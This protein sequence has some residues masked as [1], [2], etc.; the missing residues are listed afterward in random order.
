LIIVC[1]ALGVG[2]GQSTVRAQT[3]ADND[4]PTFSASQPAV[5][6]PAPSPAP[7]AAAVQLAPVSVDNVYFGDVV[8]AGGFAEITPPAPKI[9][10]AHAGYARR[11]AAAVALE[12]N[13]GFGVRRDPFTG[14][15]RMHTGVDLKAAYGQRVGAALGGM[16]VYA[17]YRGGYGN[18]VI[19][20]HGR[21]IATMYGHLSSIAVGVGQRVVAGQTIGNVGS[22]GRSTGP[23]LHYEVRARGHALNPSSVITFKG[24]SVFANGHLVDGPTIEGGDEESAKAAKPGEPPP[25]PLPLFQSDD[26]LSSF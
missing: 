23:H 10:S 2:L 1:L 20:D 17:N 25:A 14:A 5:V 26:G 19:V 18:L 9:V 22:T 24:A 11:A 12:V 15:A 13:S 7:G 21:G 16:V 6:T 4:T 8:P 3:P